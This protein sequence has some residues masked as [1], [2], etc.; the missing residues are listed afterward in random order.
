MV[1]VVDSLSYRTLA[2]TTYC[3]RTS[4]GVDNSDALGYCLDSLRRCLHCACKFL[5]MRGDD[6]EGIDSLSVLVEWTTLA[7]YLPEHTELPRDPDCSGHFLV[8]AVR[9]HYAATWWDLAPQRDLLLDE[10]SH[11]LITMS[12]WA[13]ALQVLPENAAR[14]RLLTRVLC[15]HAQL[16]AAQDGLRNL[17]ST[18]HAEVETIGSEAQ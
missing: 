13:E 8:R 16:V 6:E 12:A 11:A 4:L 18:S 1:W 5:Y 7:E 17:T 15:G 2:R 9:L 3:L 14:D 10:I